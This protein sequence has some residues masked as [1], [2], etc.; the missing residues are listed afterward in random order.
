M[1][2]TTIHKTKKVN[3]IMLSNG[4]VDIM[5]RTVMTPREANAMCAAI[6]T[7]IFPHLPTGR[8][9]GKAPELAMGFN[10]AASRDIYKE[11]AEKLSEMLNRG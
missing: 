1:Q 3:V 2:Y 9:V 10:A 7:A 4:G 5:Q 8:V 11:T 6:Q